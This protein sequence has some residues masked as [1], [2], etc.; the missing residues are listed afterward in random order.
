[1]EIAPALVGALSFVILLVLILVIKV[2]IFIAFMLAGFL[3]YLYLTDFTAASSMLVSSVWDI[4]RNY[5][6]LA[7]P[8]FM[9]MGQFAS[10]SGIGADLYDTASKWV[11]RLPGGLAIAT[12][13]GCAGFAACSGSSVTGILTFGPMSYKPMLEQG[14]DRRLTL[15]ALCCGATLGI[16]IPPSM[17]FILY[18]V[19][20][21]ESVGRLFMAGVFP[22]LLEALLYSG[23][24]LLVIKLGI[25]RAPRGTL[26]SWKE[27]VFSLRKVWGM[28]L[29]MMLVLGGIYGGV[30]TATEAGAMGAI[31][32]IIIWLSRKG[33]DS[34]QF[35]DAFTEALSL[36]CMSY[37][38]IAGG[39][40][41]ANFIGLSGLSQ[42]LIDAVIYS[43]FSPIGTIVLFLL[44]YVILGCF[45]PPIC[46]LVLTLPFLHPLFTE[47]Y[48]F[49][50]IW[51][52]VICVMGVEL[53]SITPPIGLNLFIT[54]GFAGKEVPLREIYQGVIPFV[55]ADI[56]RL[57]ILVAFPII[58]LWLP[59]MVIKPRK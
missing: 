50:G 45:V 8:L 51:L 53:A 5:V 24:I 30:F 2:P 44:A 33:F 25:F 29:L 36:T 17:S 58:S 57:V 42:M 7:I 52:G 40:Y 38:I 43:G 32:A 18:G 1:M 15:G 59:G 31:A 55:I 14:Y 20:T 26:T 22:G 9:I 49:S 10:Y 39:M 48:G 21:E 35:R 6:M 41:F 19:I 37:A 13:W 12:V 23:A 28:L 54:Q 56:I 27:K 3:G 4:C 47:V 46:V 34:A 11:G 16:M